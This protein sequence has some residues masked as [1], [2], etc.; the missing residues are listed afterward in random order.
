MAIDHPVPI[1]VFHDIDRRQDRER[2]VGLAQAFPA[3]SPVLTAERLERQEVPAALVPTAHGRAADLINRDWADADRHRAG[4]TGVG[5]DVGERGKRMAPE[6][7]HAADAHPG[8]LADRAGRGVQRG[9]HTA[10][11][12]LHGRVHTVEERFRGRLRGGEQ[13]PNGLPRP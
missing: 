3:S 9:I 12:R 5:V 7:P 11:Q 10:M 6:T 8:K 13:P 4:Q 1:G 2:V